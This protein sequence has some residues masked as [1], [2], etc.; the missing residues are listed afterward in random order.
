MVKP[1]TKYRWKKGYAK[2]IG[3]VEMTTIAILMVS[4]GRLA[5]AVIPSTPII[6][7]LLIQ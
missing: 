1:L 5:A 4:F 7:L 2:I 6:A 3:K